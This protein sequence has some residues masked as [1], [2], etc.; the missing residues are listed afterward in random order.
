[1]S[2]TWKIL[3]A[4]PS[5]KITDGF[6][7]GDG[8]KWVRQEHLPRVDKTRSDSERKQGGISSEVEEED[9]RGKRRQVGRCRMQRA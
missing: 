9:I 2:P 8:K 6:E 1:M 7:S 5:Q 4:A 3:L